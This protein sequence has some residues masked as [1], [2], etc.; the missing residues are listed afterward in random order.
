M[1]SARISRCSTTCPAESGPTT[2]QLF[3]PKSTRR[4]RPSMPSGC[5]PNT[6]EA[7]G[8][9]SMK[10]GIDR[11]AGLR[12]VQKDRWSQAAHHG[13]HARSDR[14]DRGPSHLCA[15]SRQRRRISPPNPSYVSVPSLHQRGVSV[16]P[17]W[18]KKYSRFCGAAHT[19]GAAPRLAPSTITEIESLA[20]P[21]PDRPC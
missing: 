18:F 3:V 16:P 14:Q 10:G 4:I 8:G 20:R 2:L 1:F 15:G 11:P 7:R 9:S 17:I 21:A 12:C 5:H 19:P 13:R 6:A